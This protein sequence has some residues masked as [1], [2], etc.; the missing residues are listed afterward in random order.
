MVGT[1]AQKIYELQ[2]RQEGDIF[3]VMLALDHMRVKTNEIL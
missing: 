2:G 1:K 3:H